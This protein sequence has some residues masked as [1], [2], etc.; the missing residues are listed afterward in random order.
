M[1]AGW[2]RGLDG[3]A[4]AKRRVCLE[5][6]RIAAV[7]KVKAEVLHGRVGFPESLH[8]IIRI[9]V[10]RTS[11]DDVTPKNIQNIYIKNSVINR[12]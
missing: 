10:F 3:I 9:R 2:K 11:V 1:R 7:L 6:S 12:E 5:A 4:P 8:G